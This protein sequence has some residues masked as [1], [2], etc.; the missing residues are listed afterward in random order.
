MALERTLEKEKARQ[1][2]LIKDKERL[3][4][5]CDSQRDKFEAGK[6]KWSPKE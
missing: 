1:R 3:E 4:A 2:S 5:I 6:S